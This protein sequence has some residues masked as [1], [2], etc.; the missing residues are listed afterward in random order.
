MLFDPSCLGPPAGARVAVVGGCGGMGRELVRA[1]RETG[2]F[3][4]EDQ[5]VEAP[6][7][8]LAA[9]EPADISPELRAKAAQEYRLRLTQA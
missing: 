1:L 9:S 6:D 5:Q 7:E 4:G 2:V 8:G 3:A